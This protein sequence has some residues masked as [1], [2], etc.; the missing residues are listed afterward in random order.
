M[1]NTA[2]RE[3]TNQDDYLNAVAL[4]KTDQSL[5]LVHERLKETEGEMD[6]ELL[7]RF[8]PRTIDLD[9]LLH[10]D[11]ISNEDDLIVPHPRMHERRFVLDPLCELIDNDEEHPM[12]GETWENLL[13]ETEDQQCTKTDITL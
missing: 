1:F 5:S 4:I 3:V 2:P 11:S 10:G 13:K 7:Y 9:L 8:G 12:L 6:K